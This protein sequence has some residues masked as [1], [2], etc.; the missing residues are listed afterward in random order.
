[1]VTP[2]GCGVE[3]AW[4][5]LK[6]G[7][8]GIATITGF[9][10]TPFDSR[11]AGEIKDFTPPDF[12]DRKEL[13]RLDKFVQYALV[14]A[15]EAATD[16]GLDG[17][18]FQAGRCGVIIGSGIGGLR[19]MEAEHKNL[20]AFGP[21]RISPFLIPMLIPDIAAGRVA[22]L[23]HFQGP[24][25]ATV[26]ACAS[27]A[28]ALGIATR[29]IQYG[30]IDL[31]ICGGS[32]SCITPLGLGGFCSMKALSIRNEEPE[33]AS[34]PFDRQRDGFVMAEG[35]GIFVLEELE[36]AIKRRTKKI[37]GEIIG[38]GASADAYHITAPDP[39][40]IGMA[41]AMEAAIADAGI[42]PQEIE[43][44]NAHGTSTAL[45]DVVETRAIKKIFGEKAW[46]IPVSSTKSMTGHMLGAAGA[47]ELAVCCL[48]IRDQ[49]LPPTINYEEPDS[50][51]DLDYVPNKARPARVRTALSN[52]F[53]FG[54]HNATLI[55]KKME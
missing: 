6:S 50:E 52:S 11:I 49:I 24:N 43:Y 32:E 33:K 7:K 20:L 23:F 44:I 22:M 28:H 8:S 31:A 15:R 12:L 2:V 42:L 34:R 13:R 4:E 54:G 17:V 46:K 55:V 5:A 41:L 25:F 38:Y 37:Y 26:S 45:N 14:A 36:H 16:A 19:I 29:A 10:P 18:S 27:G 40:G 35:A 21:G 30:E 3:K 9:D 48:A 47:V 1:L 53:G 39:E 51:C